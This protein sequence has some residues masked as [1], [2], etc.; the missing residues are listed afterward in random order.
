LHLGQDPDF[1]ACCAEESESR[2]LR[3]DGPGLLLHE[4][5][6]GIR[7]VEQIA[8]AAGVVNAHGQGGVLN[9]ESYV[10]VAFGN[11]DGC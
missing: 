2:I 5:Y 3:N 9:G 8:A 1:A 11:N 10:D 6:D 4:K 7:R